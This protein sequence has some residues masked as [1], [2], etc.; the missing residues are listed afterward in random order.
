MI[1]KMSLNSRLGFAGARAG[2]VREL[3]LTKC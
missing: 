1:S 2:G 3:N